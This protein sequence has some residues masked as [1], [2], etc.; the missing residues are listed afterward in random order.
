[1]ARLTP[2]EKQK[3]AEAQ[4]LKNKK[5][6]EDFD[7]LPPTQ[8]KIVHS[9]VAV[10]AILVCILLYNMFTYDPPAVEKE[11]EVEKTP[12]ERFKSD[13]LSGWDGSCRELEKHV[14]GAMHD[15]DS[16]EHVETRGFEKDSA[17]VLIMTYRGKNLFGGK[18]QSTI[19]ATVTYD[20][21]VI[22]VQ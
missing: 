9:I 17:M 16:Y 6:K 8:K 2:E 10:F 3:R 14:K 13:C 20:C 7:R 15:P 19:T 5:A 11:P 1:M 22:K 12:L 21:Q 18:V 4:D